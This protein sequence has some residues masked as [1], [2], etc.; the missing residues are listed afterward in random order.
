MSQ[1]ITRS[2]TDNIQGLFKR[3]RN[4]G[5]V[6]PSE[7]REILGPDNVNFLN[8]AVELYE[9]DPV[10]GRLYRKA[11]EDM[12]T[13]VDRKTGY[14]NLKLLQQVLIVK[15][16]AYKKVLLS[17]LQLAVNVGKVTN[18]SLDQ[19]LYHFLSLGSA[20]SKTSVGIFWLEILSEQFLQFI[21][22]PEEIDNY[23]MLGSPYDEQ[24]YMQ[25]VDF[26]RLPPPPPSQPKGGYK[27]HTK[28]HVK[29]YAKKRSKKHV[30]KHAR[31]TK[32][33]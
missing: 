33:V 23:R 30:K 6:T 19:Y 26:L 15:A 2:L 31:N 3:F 21:N 29:K 13:G 22:T 14:Y 9:R 16:D 24:P 8:L 27:K 7:V 12:L 28:K 5:E 25:P 1:D 17:G 20:S 10:I 4:K 18:A 32:R 11:M